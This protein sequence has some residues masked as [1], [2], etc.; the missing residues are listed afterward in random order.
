MK[1]EFNEDLSKEYYHIQTYLAISEP[2]S[3]EEVKSMFPKEELMCWDTSLNYIHYRL[4]GKNRLLVGGS[5]NLT[6]YYPKYYYSPSTIN[7]FIKKI[8][9]RFPKL[10]DV[11]FPYYWS[12]LIDVTRDL[13]PIAD[14][15]QRNKSIQYAMGCAGLPWATYCGDYLARRVLNPEKTEDLSEFLGLH[16]SYFLSRRFQRFFGKIITFGINHLKQLFYG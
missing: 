6:A 13:T 14:Y 7:S 10:K 16:R 3:K 11:D 2:L 9:K 4:I 15:D 5:S 8:K 12:G 1:R